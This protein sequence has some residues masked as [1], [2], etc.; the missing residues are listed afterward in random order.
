MNFKKPK[1]WDYRKIS[2]WLIILLPLSVIYLLINWIRRITLVFRTY[3][4]HICPIICVGNIYLG[5]TGKTPLARKIFNITK[6]LGKNP[7]FVKKHYDY[8]GDEIGM[9]KE[10]GATF[11]TS[12][13]QAGIL[14]SNANN[15]DV[16][17]LDDGFQ[18]FS[19]RPDFAILCF[20]SKQLIGNGFV[21]PS[22]P[23]RERL[24]AVLRANCIVIN[25][26][27]TE[28]TIE[29]EKKIKRNLG[30]KKLYFFYSKY[31]IKNIEKLK[32]KEITAFAG[33]GN[34]SNFFDLLKENN[35]NVKKTYTFPDHHNYSEKDFYKII[36]DKSTK[37]VTTEK[38]Y[39][40]MNEKQKENCD[41]VEVNL[42]IE[43]KNEFESLL[44]GYL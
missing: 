12:T 7:A 21:I 18:D 4:K 2:F 10:T 14:L 44:L 24:N 22:G 16:I 39:Y 6:S 25:G 8:L 42:E 31:K 35:L 1:F 17:I 34:P 36:G 9:L 32:N 43:N 11:A 26:D 13:R 41:Y 28:E 5:G 15:H 3:P 23:L 33:I 27:K 20:N 38:D 19:I 40:R 30:N 37:I 29:F